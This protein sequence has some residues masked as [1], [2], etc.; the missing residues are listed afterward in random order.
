MPGRIFTLAASLLVG[1]ALTAPASTGQAEAATA[2]VITCNNLIAQIGGLPAGSPIT[3]T[4]DASDLIA[5]CQASNNSQLTVTSPALPISITLTA[6]QTQTVPFTVSDGQG[7]TASA[8]II[9][10]R[11]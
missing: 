8:A 11:N 9:A 7:D 4:Y 3:L 5:Q 6:G 10:S 2:P 1:A